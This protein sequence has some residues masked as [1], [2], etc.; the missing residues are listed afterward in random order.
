[1]KGITIQLSLLLFVSFLA[2]GKAAP[3]KDGRDLESMRARGEVRGSEA[4]ITGRVILPPEERELG[5]Q[6]LLALDLDRLL[7]CDKA[8]LTFD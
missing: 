5:P 4:K 6:V 2:V 8:D 3:Q 7:D 1:M